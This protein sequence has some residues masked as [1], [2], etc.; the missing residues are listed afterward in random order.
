MAHDFYVLSM[1]NLRSA[2]QALRAIFANDEPIPD[3]E[4]GDQAKLETCCGCTEAGAFGLQKYPDLPSKSAKLFYS[5]IKTHPFPNGNKRFAFAITLGYIA[6]NDHRL[7]AP[8]GVGYEV[9]TWVADSD[10]HSPDGDPDKIIATLA[11]FF[12]ENIVS[13]DW[14][15]YSAKMAETAD[16]SS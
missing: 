16:E 7:I 8:E 4:E 3:W 11:E 13:F 1:H 9:A 2:H 14:D 15:A 5:T 12:R 6:L 10:P